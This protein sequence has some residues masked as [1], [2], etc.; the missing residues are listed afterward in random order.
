MLMF[1]SLSVGCPGVVVDVQDDG[2]G[3]MCLVDHFVII[4][5]FLTLELLVLV[6]DISFHQGISADCAGLH[7]LVAELVEVVV[8]LPRVRAA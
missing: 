3:W 1:H 2:N 5:K 8:F 6:V 7:L 4:L